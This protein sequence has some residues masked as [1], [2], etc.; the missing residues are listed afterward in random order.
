MKRFTLALVSLSVVLNALAFSTSNYVQDGLIACWDGIENA[1]KDVH[2]SEATAWTD[3]VGGKKFALTG[4]TVDADRMTFAGNKD[5]YGVLSAEDT[6]STFV[7]AKD[8]TLE[9]VYALEKVPSANDYQVILQSSAAAGIAFGFTAAKSLVPHTSSNTSSPQNSMYSF[10][11][12]TATNSVS[13]TYNNGVPADV[14][15]NGLVV[16]PNGNNHW[17]YPDEGTY[18]GVR[19]NKT[20]FFKGSIYC[21]RLYDRK[22]TEAE[23]V[24]NRSV[25]Q[26][27]FYGDP[28]FSLMISCNPVIVGT[29]SP[30]RGL[31]SGFLSGQSCEVSCGETIATN[32]EKSAEY[33]CVGWKLYDENDKEVSNGTDTIFTYV[34]PTPAEY[35]RLE[36]QW[37]KVRNIS[38]FSDYVQDGL[39]AFW[40]GIGNNGVSCHADNVT[41]WRD[42]IGGYA[43]SL[44][45]V[46]VGNNCMVFHGTKTDKLCDSYGLLSESDT[47]ST[48]VEA[49]NG[50]MEIV[51]RLDNGTAQQV[52]LQSSAKSG[53]GFGIYRT[54]TLIIAYS[55]EGYK[56]TFSHNSGTQLNTVSVCYNQ[57]LP[58][59]PAYINESKIT[60]SSTAAW[61]NPDNKTYI[62][63]RASRAT[64]YAFAGSIYCIRL[65]NRQLTDAEIISNQKVDLLR[66]NNEVSS[67]S[68]LDISSTIEGVGLPNP[69]Y[70]YIADLKAGDT[71]L[72]SCGEP[73][74][75]DETGDGKY[76]C[77]GWKLYDTSGRVVSSG[78]GKSFDY[79]HPTPAAYRRLE[80]Q[81]TEGSGLGLTIYVR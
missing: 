15:G 11:T 65:Y 58:I 13:V 63:A 71:R 21:I 49:A 20:S 40:D 50:T 8:G 72:L 1:G 31:V 46:S 35:R 32:A 19:A 24:L 54:G 9:I 30:E 73:L 64:D 28:T 42:V 26:V 78:R 29:P 10:E 69:Q 39:I 68:T 37:E 79:T 53:I 33:R 56:N 17:W 77:T 34:H 7:A 22:L 80:W 52:L 70:G 25:D 5:S 38:H 67:E 23:I 62:G 4:V 44:F 74:W 16:P 36:W 81:W 55:G 18:I 76:S 45:N 3:I 61:S 2:V 41:L 75:I 59:S 51:Y 43:F 48:F 66:Y 12:G 14:M 57:T 6:V 47:E 27:R 60:G